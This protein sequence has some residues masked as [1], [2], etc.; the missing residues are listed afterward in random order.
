MNVFRSNWGRAGIA[1]AL[2]VSIGGVGFVQAAGGTASVFTPVE[3][4]RLIDTRAATNV[5]PRSTPL[6]ANETATFSA[7]GTNG[8]CVLPTGL[9][10]LSANVT[11]VGATSDTFLTLF[12]ADG[13]DPCRRT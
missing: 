2:A 5:G 8:N 7:A 12:P 6:G 3:P 9:T 10:G 13:A 1:V 11:A 4:C